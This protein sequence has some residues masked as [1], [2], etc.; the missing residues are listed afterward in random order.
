ML[1]CWFTDFVRSRFTIIPPVKSNSFHFDHSTIHSNPSHAS[2]SAILQSFSHYV[3]PFP[4]HGHSAT[5]S[6]SSQ[7]DHSSIHSNPSKASHSAQYSP[8]HSH[9]AT[10]FNLSHFTVIQPF[11]QIFPVVWKPQSSPAPGVD[12]WQGWLYLW[13]PSSERSHPFVGRN[14]GSVDGRLTAFFRVYASGRF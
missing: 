5:Q 12:G 1:F 9:S 7:F 3:Q 13:V 8:F 4:F 2:Q 6:N 10:Q 11:I 14:W